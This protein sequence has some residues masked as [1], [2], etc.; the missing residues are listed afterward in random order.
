MLVSA[1]RVAVYECPSEV[2]AGSRFFTN[3]HLNGG[4]FG[5]YG[6]LVPP[7]D[8]GVRPAEFDGLP[9]RFVQ[10]GDGL[11][12]T[13]AFSE[14]ALGLSWGPGQSRS[15]WRTPSVVD[16]SD[17]PNSFLRRCNSLAGEPAAFQTNLFAKCDF[18]YCAIPLYSHYD[19]PNG[20]DCLNF[21]DSGSV[22]TWQGFK[23]LP[24][25]SY[26]GG[27][28]VNVAFCDGRVDSFGPS[29]DLAIWR[30]IGTAN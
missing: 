7:D 27:A 19:V 13:A 20:R 21:R 30:E 3:Y 11:S 15:Y 25:S 2:D 14:H 28:I 8:D 29:V 16:L 12:N 18:A 6:W 23:S 10:V 4:V 17:D 26:H 9:G 24:A 1:G 5:S 22:G